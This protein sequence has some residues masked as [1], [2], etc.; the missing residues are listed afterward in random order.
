MGQNRDSGGPG[1]DYLGCKQGH[2]RFDNLLIAFFFY[3]FF[4]VYNLV[5]AGYVT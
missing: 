2:K 3:P 5:D 4:P 1:K